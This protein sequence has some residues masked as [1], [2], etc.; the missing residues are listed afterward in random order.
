MINRRDLFKA[1]PLPFISLP[2][3]A[4]AHP[5]FDP[6]KEYSGLHKYT[7]KQ[8]SLYE[9]H[10]P[11]QVIIDA[12]VSASFATPLKYDLS[13]IHIPSMNTDKSDPLGQDGYFG[14]RYIPGYQLTSMAYDPLSGQ[15]S[16]PAIQF[17]KYWQALRDN[18]DRIS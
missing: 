2:S 13:I 3:I 18:H 9:H 12:V 5:D 4:G 14:W 6:S 10:I 17:R 1:A 15:Y 16:Y 7:D 8:A 11:E